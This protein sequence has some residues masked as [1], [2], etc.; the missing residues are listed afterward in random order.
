MKGKVS[1]RR[2]PGLAQVV[3]FMFALLLASSLAG[4]TG[5]IYYVSTTGND[6]NSGL[7]Q[8]NSEA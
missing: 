5:A 8:S 7:G 3:L 6:S 1:I 2:S 4:Q